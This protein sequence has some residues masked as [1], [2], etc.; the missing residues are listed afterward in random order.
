M[1]NVVRTRT[2]PVAFFWVY[3]WVTKFTHT[4]QYPENT[5]DTRQSQ[6]WRR[7]NTKNTNVRQRP[8]SLGG[9][10]II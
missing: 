3:L 5:E 9:L 10:G 7:T 2:A 8:A 4:I 1:R 6:S